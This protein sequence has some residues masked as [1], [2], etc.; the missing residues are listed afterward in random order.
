MPL[1][2]DDSILFICGCCIED[3][4]LQKADCRRVRVYFTVLLQIFLS[5]PAVLNH[6][7]ITCVFI[8]NGVLLIA[9]SLNFYEPADTHQR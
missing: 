2:A 9:C 6:T 7:C 8:A 3:I 4:G 1:Y 5:V